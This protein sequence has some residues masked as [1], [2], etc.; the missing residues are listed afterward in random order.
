MTD[1]MIKKLGEQG[2]VMQINFYTAFLDSAVDNNNVK[3]RVA[4]KKLLDEKGLSPDDP[5]AK[6]VI[7]QFEI[8]HPWK[9]TPIETVA[10]HIDHVVKIAGIDH[11]AFGS[12]YDG[13]DN[14]LP[15]G[16]ED[17]STFPNL[18]YVLLKRGYTEEDIAKICYK[19]VWRVWN[20]VEKTAGR[21]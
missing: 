3:N 15:I 10:N 17:V 14:H 5:E 9:T 16:L 8:D 21:G 4:L 11:V 2:G 1:D 6:P 18:I 13:V 19:N 20:A 12:D 7:E